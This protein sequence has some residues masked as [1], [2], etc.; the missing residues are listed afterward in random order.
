[1]ASRISQRSRRSSRSFSRLTWNRAMG[2][3]AEARIAT[4]ATQMMR[5]T[6]VRPGS[7]GLERM[8]RFGPGECGEEEAD[9]STA[10]AEAPPSVEMTVPGLGWEWRWGFL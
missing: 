8:A 7:G 9:F 10:A 1:M 4:M 3:A 6:R 2:I 5:S